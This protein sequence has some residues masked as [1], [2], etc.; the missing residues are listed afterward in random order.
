[1]ARVHLF[2]SSTPH[3]ERCSRSSSNGEEFLDNE[4]PAPQLATTTTTEEGHTLDVTAVPSPNPTE[5]SS[6]EPP[7]ESLNLSQFRSSSAALTAA[8]LQNAHSDVDVVGAMAAAL[9]VKPESLQMLRERS[10]QHQEGEQKNEKELLGDKGKKAVNADL[11]DQAAAATALQLL[12]LSQSESKSEK[13]D[14]IAEEEEKN[15]GSD[16]ELNASNVMLIANYPGLTNAAATPTVEGLEL[17]N[18]EIMQDYKRGTWTREEDELL[19][20]G[21]K[22]YGY[23][24][25]KE[26]ANTIPGRKGKQLKQRWDNTLASKYVDRE[27]LQNKIRN[28]EELQQHQQHQDVDI[29][30][31]AP[32]SPTGEHEDQKDDKALRFLENA[33]WNEI[34]QK[35]TEKAKEGN[36]EAIEALLSQALLGTVANTSPPTTTTTNTPPIGVPSTSSSPHLMNYSRAPSATTSAPAINFADATALAFFT[37][38]LN[39]QHNGEGSSNVSAPAT[40]TPSSSLSAAAALA[41]N[42]YFLSNLSFSQAGNDNA[43]AVAAAAVAAVAQASAAAA[44]S[45]SAAGTPHGLSGP[46]TPLGEI[47]HSTSSPAPRATPGQKRRRSDPALAETQS[48]AMSIYASSAPITTTINNQTQTVYPCLFPNCGKTFARLYNLKSHSR[49]HTDDRP[50]ICHI[51]EAAFSRNH[52]LKRHVKIHGG[53]KPYKCMGCNKSFSRLDALKRHKSNQRNKVA[54]MNT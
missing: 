30:D 16:Q 38:Q 33:D 45:N 1:M 40:T 48:A 47:G 22:K 26:I 37:Q 8:L 7:K 19:L 15:R 17:Q 54:C 39:H 14:S 21:I 32:S 9:S 43:M 52:D 42:P 36:Q 53:D 49:T 13:S 35:I 5:T 3:H 20:A 44:S 23:G 24:R 4:A 46:S 50:F 27:W 28:D 51:C 41:N 34:A 18:E 29:E 25:W 11:M 31:S 10:Q 12:G 6:S 2:S